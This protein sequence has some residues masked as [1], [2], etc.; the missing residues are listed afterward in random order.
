MYSEGFRPPSL[1]DLYAETSFFKGNNQLQPEKS[2]QFE[3]GQSWSTESF[4]FSSSL[5]LLNYKDLLQSSVL[6]SSQFTKTNIGKAQSYG[7]SAKLDIKQHNWVWH[8]SHSYLLARENTSNTPLLFSPEHQFFTSFSY[9]I[10]ERSSIL[11]QQSL[12]SSL[13]DLD[14]INN[15]NV[16]LTP[17]ASTDILFRL[18][19]NKKISVQAG[20]YNLFNKRRELTYG[21]PEPQR[22]AA[23]ALEAV[24]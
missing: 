1:T 20:V 18:G 15:R 11:F 21:Y 4:T 9:L 22:R 16:N 19:I 8:V 7:L 10:T 12:W 14:F 13:V 17:W 5:F 3:L 2:Q 23:L 24:F 6:P